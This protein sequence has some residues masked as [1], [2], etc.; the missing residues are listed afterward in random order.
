[1]INLKK[2]LSLILVL[3]LSLN[4]VFAQEN[5][6]IRKKEFLV[7]KEG[8]KEAWKAAK[9]G[10]SFYKQGK[11]FYREA[12]ESYLKAYAYNENNAALNYKLGISYLYSDNK[13]EAI[14]YL[15]KA[16]EKNN[17]VSKDIHLQLGKAYQMNYEFSNAIK[18]YKLHKTITP[19]R[20]LKKKNIDIDKYIAECEYGISI[21]N[22]PA[23]IVIENMGKTVNSEADD[24][25]PVLD[26]KNETMYFT[27]RRPSKKNNK[28]N[29]LDQKYSEDIYTSKN[30]SED[31]TTSQLLSKK[32]FSKKSEAVVAISPDNSTLYVYKS[33]KGGNIYTTKFKNGKWSGTSSFSKVNSRFRETSMSFSADGKTCYFVS[34]RKDKN[35]VGKK[36]IY[37]MR[38]NAKGRWMKPENLGTT[39]NTQFDEEAVYVSRDGKALYFSSN[40]HPSMGGYDIFKSEIGESGKWGVPK[41]IGYPVNTPDDD[42]YFC[43]S[44]NKKIGYLSGNR[45][46]SIGGT[47]IYKLIFLGAE[48]PVVP[49]IESSAMAF[50]IMDK[51]SLII[52]RSELVTIDSSIILAGK[53]MDSESKKGIIAKLQIID[54]EKSA[55]AALVISDSSGNYKIKLPQKKNYGIE[56]TARGYLLYL[57]VLNIKNEE[58]DLIQKDFQ[59]NELSV[60][61]KVVLKNIFFETGKAT[62]K[63]ES[64]QQLDNVISFMKENPTLTLEISGHTDNVGS[65]TANT[66]LSLLRA[67]SVV[68]YMV[69]Q[70]IEPNRL[71]SKGYGPKQP[72]AK[73]T[74]KEGKAQN[75]RVEFKITGK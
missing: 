35:A 60:G 28:R 56:I 18:S 42:L 41:N 71:T 27:S 7:K 3:V 69:S 8:S 5:K 14:K 17:Q 59:L 73:N 55:L 58:N 49:V 34:D 47:D 65:I 40:G 19:A 50:E 44:D 30:K 10:D 68:K 6:K 15:N 39:I 67:K 37:M 11:P 32:L 33:P 29:P 22:E 75:R 9:K 25:Y 48:K 51:K 74:T 66:S 12:R 57:D 38:Q 1:M 23:R 45:E 63:M 26:S 54:S 31:W 64:Y 21:I 2:I 24:Y 62:L 53:I 52:G 4:I 70:G 72:I 20:K 61:A 13:S 36:D 46:N 43:L 16:F